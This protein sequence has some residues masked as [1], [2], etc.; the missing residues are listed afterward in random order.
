[1][2]AE[3]FVEV[4]SKEGPASIVT[5]ANNDAHVSATWNSYI[6]L[7]DDGKLLI[8]AAWMHQTESNIAVNDKVKMIFGSKEVMG[9]NSMGAGFLLEGTARFLETGKEVDMMKTKFSWL[10]R[11]LEITPANIKQTL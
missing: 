4:L 9:K 1:M 11:V 7:T 3:K 5:W 6:N 2:F 8:P 10:T